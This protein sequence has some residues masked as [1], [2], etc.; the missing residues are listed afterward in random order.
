MR[1]AACLIA[2]NGPIRF[3][4]S[5]SVISATS[6]SKMLAMPARD[7]GVGEHHVEP[8][9][10][11]YGKGH[12]PDHVLLAARIDPDR[13]GDAARGRDR[14]GGVLDALADVGGDDPAALAREQQRGGAAD[15]RCQHR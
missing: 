15:P 2:R 6:V 3:T 9:E 14:S 4:R 8:A 10:R 11:L 1:G 13:A 12:G 7:A 5:T